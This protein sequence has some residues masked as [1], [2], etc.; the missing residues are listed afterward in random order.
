MGRRPSQET[1]WKIQELYKRVWA[2]EKGETIHFSQK[3]FTTL[4][5]PLR[6]AAEKMGLTLYKGKITQK[7]HHVICPL[8]FFPD[9]LHI[10]PCDI[11]DCDYYTWECFVIA[12]ADYDREVRGYTMEILGKWIVKSWTEKKRTVKEWKNANKRLYQHISEKAEAKGRIG[13][14]ESDFRRLFSRYAY[15]LYKR[16]LAQVDNLAHFAIP[17]FLDGKYVNFT[18]IGYYSSLFGIDYDQ[19]IKAPQQG[20][21]K[22]RVYNE[23]ESV[24]FSATLFSLCK[25]LFSLSSKKFTDL[26]F[27][28]QI[29]VG[30]GGF[31]ISKRCILYWN[32]YKNEEVTDWRFANYWSL[33]GCVRL[34][35]DYRIVKYATELNEEREWLEDEGR[36]NVYEFGKFRNNWL[37]NDPP[38]FWKHMGFPLV[39]S[40]YHKTGWANAEM[41]FYDAADK[42]LT[43]RR[44]AEILKAKCLPIILPA[45]PHHGVRSNKNC[46]IIRWSL[47][48]KKDMDRM[49]A[50]LN[51]SSSAFFYEH[52][53]IKMLYY[54]FM[55]LID[56]QEMKTLR[57][58]LKRA[59][60]K[61]LSECTLQVEKPKPEEQHKAYLLAAL[62]FAQEIFLHAKL[63]NQYIPF[64]QHIENMKS[65]MRC[66]ATIEHF[67]EFV[68]EEVQKAAEQKKSVVF[69]QD[70]DGVYLYYKEYWGAFKRYCSDHSVAVP[71]SAGA[72]RREVLEPA[73][74]IKPQYRSSNPNVRN[75]FDYHKK[76]ADG[77]KAIVLSVFPGILETLDREE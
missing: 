6:A 46:L 67:A 9:G 10:F 2:G 65:L 24:L 31:P 7:N 60:K 69:Y 42:P 74:Y 50:L 14:V 32:R 28:L 37:K 52:E 11:A 75:R 22:I 40:N 13:L 59:Y 26:D 58:A 4:T 38:A 25:P 53:R 23:L 54:K 18:H 76:N 36:G 43:T 51:K 12:R 15:E 39:Y 72:F 66:I 48:T 71:F 35:C 27:A 47:R 34:W 55:N 5:I 41:E 57:N 30:D 16:Q 29:V 19:W 21:R 68:R 8:L 62:Y 45:I 73:Q 44:V 49:E 20:A 70:A 17:R 1:T 33:V 3:D 61:A 77:E 64:K 56:G 63:E